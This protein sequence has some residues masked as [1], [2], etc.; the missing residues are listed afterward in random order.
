MAGSISNLVSNL[1]EGIHKI[2][3]KYGHNDKKKCETCEIKYQYY[4][5]FL[6]YRN[7]K[8]NLIEYKCL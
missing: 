4:D 6:Q 3:C 1:S 2:K 5:C 8:D 7:F